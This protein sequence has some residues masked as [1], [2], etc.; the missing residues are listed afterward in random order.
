MSENLLKQIV[1]CPSCK[2]KLM[3]A[4]ND[5]CARCETCGN[6]HNKGKYSWDFI[7]TDKRLD[8]PIWETWQQ[9]QNNGVA[10]YKA[11]PTNNLSIGKRNDCQMF[12]KFCGYH[13]IVLDVGCGPQPCPAYFD[14]DAAQFVGVDPLVDDA[15]SEF[16]RLKA[17]AEY[18]PFQDHVFDHV[19]FSTTLDHFAEPLV[20]LNEAVRVCKIDGEVDV[21]FG[22][23]S[24]N[25]PRPLQSPEWYQQLQK[26]ELAEDIFHI[27]RLNG[28][29]IN[30][31]TTQAGLIIVDSQIH[32]IDEY[33]TNYFYRLKTA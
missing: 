5:Q 28:V 4:H 16:P 25:A 24:Q 9:V 22:E 2:G 17:L 26:P 15:P 23:K 21:W 30:W 20:A 14:L 31:L 33:R 13:G 27:K 18:L 8:S 3:F 6:T 10:S 7:P 1:A 29:E 11:D 32:K 19:L 12:S